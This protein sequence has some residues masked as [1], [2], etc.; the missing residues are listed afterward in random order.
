MV[1]VLEELKGKVVIITG[2]NKGIGAGCAAAFRQ[3]GC[4]VVI[5]GR[6]KQ[7][8]EEFAAELA[9]SGPGT[10]VFFRCDVSD[11]DQVSEL[12]AYTVA[13]FGR[14]DCFINN[15]GYLSKRRHIDEISIRDFEDVLKTN[16]IGVFS[17]CKYSL[18]HLRKTR[19]CIINM[20]S[21]LGVV[22]REG[23]SIYAATKGAIISLTKALAI[24]ESG[25]G[26][27]VRLWRSDGPVCF[28]QA[29]WR[30]ILPERRYTQPPVWSW[31]PVSG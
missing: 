1:P 21:I 18:P 3:C 10:S 15:A 14:L 11:A 6:D 28:W 7:Q 5:A 12:V 22:G 27:R 24:D 23:A 30:A 9:G 20:S 16:L 13:R 19:G 17:G 2:G 31:A 8:G 25:N 4:N 26:D 29:V